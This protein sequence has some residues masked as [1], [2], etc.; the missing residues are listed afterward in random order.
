M[1]TCQTRSRRRLWQ[2]IRW[3]H[4]IRARLM[5]KWTL[6]HVAFDIC[7]LI[8]CNIVFVEA[9]PIFLQSSMS[10]SIKLGFLKNWMRLM[11]LHGL[12]QSAWPVKYWTYLC[13]LTPCGVVMYSSMGMAMSWFHAQSWAPPGY[14]HLSS[15]PSLGEHQKYI[16][17]LS[18]AITSR[19]L[20]VPH[21]LCAMQPIHYLRSVRL[22]DTITVSLAVWTWI[23]SWQSL[24]SMVSQ[25][26]SSEHDFLIAAA[27][28]CHDMRPT[29]ADDRGL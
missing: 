4:R 3:L 17:G 19:R 8:G 6:W 14:A 9:L 13:S 16:W 23:K 24:V 5:A 11:I 12:L 18:V 2:I 7:Y 21:K 1:T 29:R 26:W 28:S 22:G 15:N 25:Q 10:R 27:G 20:A